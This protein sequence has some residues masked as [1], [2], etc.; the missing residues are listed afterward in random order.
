MRWKFF[1]PLHIRY[2]FEMNSK[3]SL[4]DL[5]HHA[6]TS[7][8]DLVLACAAV[9]LVYLFAWNWDWSELI[10]STTGKYEFIQL[11]ELQLALFAAAVALAW[12]SWRRVVDLR[13]EVELRIKAEQELSVLLAEN[14]ALGEHARQQQEADRR[15]L[16]REIHDEIGQ[17]LTAIRLCAATLPKD[18]DP[19][20]A[21]K[22]KRIADHA[23]HVQRCISSLL[24]RLRPV[25]LDECGLVDGL[26]YLVRE[27]S[28]QNPRTDYRLTIAEDCNDLPDLINIAVYRIVQEAMTNVAR[29]AQAT[30]ADIVIRK[31]AESG[32]SPHLLVEIRDNGIGFE[33]TPRQTC[34]GLTGM[35]ERV[36][37]LGGKFTLVSGFD[38]GV[39]LTAWIPLE[40]QS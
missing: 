24:Q 1:A 27:C 20:A 21:E 29:H 5:W 3:M 2:H 6:N 23:G 30:H 26:Q 39:Q 9:A 18:A 32:Q 8:R 34:F 25:A 14:R 15:A 12:F 40:A 35:R 37:A 7:R 22:A 31:P 33:R 4:T 16:A 13:R 11:D 10:E 19:A 36:E 17:Y 38:A 28:C